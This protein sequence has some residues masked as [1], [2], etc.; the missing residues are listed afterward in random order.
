VNKITFR[1]KTDAINEAKKLILTLNCG[2]E[3]VPDQGFI[4]C[5]EPESIIRLKIQALIDEH[6]LA[7]SILVNENS[8]WSKRKILQNLDRIIKHG[9]LYDKRKPRFYPIG[10]ML[11]IPTGGDPIL[12]KY[13]YEFLHLNCGTIAHY[14][15]QGWIATYPTLDDLKALF[16]KNEY[17]KPVRE[18]IPSWKTD[19]IEIVD[20]IEQRLFPLRS[21][22]RAH[23]K[24]NIK[25]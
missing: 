21:Y 14:N 6:N 13:F 8:V 19:V 5:S 9:R 23:N 1:G 20:A 24:R 22:I 25:Y 4:A 15:I 18:D 7:A 11:K 12:S 17:G 2:I 16:K 3:E 10:S